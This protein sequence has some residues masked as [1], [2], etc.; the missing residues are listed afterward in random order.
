ME[1]AIGEEII[2]NNLKQFL[3]VLSVSL[4]VATLPQVFGWFRQIP[5]TLLLVVVGLGLAIADVRLVTLSPGLIL[6]I[7][8]PPLLFEAAWNLHWSELKRDWLPILLY[9]VFGVLISIIGVAI[10]L[11]QFA[12]ISLPIA[13]LIAAS[14][15][16]TDPV[17]VTA[18]FREL[19][20]DSRLVTLME[21]ESLFNDGMAVVAFGF[22]VALP[23]GTVQLG[24]QPVLVELF[25]VVGIGLGV[26]CL[27]GFSISYLTQR[28]DLP[29]VEQSLT[30]VSAYGTYLISEDLGGSGVIG[31]V[32]TGLILGN[33]GSRIGMNPRTRI[34]VSQFWEFLAFFVNSIVFLLIGDQIRFANLRDNLQIIIITVIAMILIRAVAIFILSRISISLTKSEIS[35]P[36]QTI[37]WWGGL[38]GSVAIALALSVPDILP[39]REEIIAIVFGVVLFTL[40]VQ[41]LTIKP[42]LEKL[43]LLG[44][45]KLRESYLELVARDVALSR[46]LQ[47]LQA[48]QRPGIDQEFY[49]YQETLI[50]G[51]ITELQI[52]IEKLQTEY[53]NL[54]NTTMELFREELLAIEADTYAEFVRAGRLNKELAP[55]LQQVLQPGN[56]L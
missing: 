16:A 3:L 32:T 31:V 43:N 22:L 52:K 56:G 14:L 19:G 5:Y 33:F 8:L 49:R 9:A 7:F 4:G 30:L 25:T 20:V 21:G 34:I 28:F 11:D 17:S 39:E 2:A 13:L 50:K 1:S 35:L 38:R 44:D 10:A 41:G 40:L 37:L 48:D 26:G 42:L 24:L 15:S 29:M 55:M 6:L 23:L 27:I 51:E 54:Q 18:L 47:Y 46:V 36:E 12:N 53:P 45:T